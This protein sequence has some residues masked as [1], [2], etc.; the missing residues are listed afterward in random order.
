MMSLVDTVLGKHFLVTR[1]KVGTS[2]W[3]EV[4]GP[5]EDARSTV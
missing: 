4:L 2:D 1:G 3:P 5:L